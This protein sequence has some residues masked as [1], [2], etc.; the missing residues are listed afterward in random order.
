MLNKVADLFTRLLVIWVL[1]AVFCG[2]I[3]PNLLIKFKP[4]TEWFFALTMFGIGMVLS[5]GDFKPIFKNPK[6]VLLGTLAQFAIMPALGFFLAKL[7]RLPPPLA[8]GVILV[9]SVP[10]AMASNMI[11]YL[12]GAD[13]ALS[14]A[15]TSFSTFLSPILTPAFTYIFAHTYIEI[16]FWPMFLSII[17]MVILPLILGLGIKYILKQKLDKIIK[18]F[19]ALSAVFIAF[20][21]GLV[22][23]L[24]RDYLKN[25]TLMIFLAVFLHNLLGLVFGYGA[26]RLF[27]F[28]KKRS[29]TL[30]IEVGMQMQV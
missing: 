14:I 19:P 20:I 3:W 25:I 24:N 5:F 18:L 6:V 29:L 16:K 12:A 7:L 23:A 21:C 28:D 26:G 1:L 11:S 10:G 13:V 8:L 15:L 4:Y 2:C 27:C 30:S 17:K 22:V 9:G